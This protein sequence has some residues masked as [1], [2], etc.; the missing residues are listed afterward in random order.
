MR[1]KH[2]CN[3][4]HKAED[5]LNPPKSQGSKSSDTEVGTNEKIVNFF[6]SG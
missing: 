2:L 5:F 4:V 6:A 3:I 1:D